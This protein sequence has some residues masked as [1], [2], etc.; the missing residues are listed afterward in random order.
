MN[1]PFGTPQPASGGTVTTVPPPLIAHLCK[2]LTDKLYEKRKAAALDVERR[3]RDL[4]HKEQVSASDATLVVVEILEYLTA[5]FIGSSSRHVRNGGLISLAAVAIALGPKVDTYLAAIVP[6]ILRCFF[7][8]DSRV[9]Y[10]ALESLYNVSKVARIAILRYF[11]QIF[12]AL[13]KLAADSDISVKNGSELLDRLLKDVVAEAVGVMALRQHQ[14]AKTAPKS[15]KQESSKVDSKGNAPLTDPLLSDVKP[16]SAQN[17]TQSNAEEE[18]DGAALFNLAG[19]IPLLTNRVQTLNPY[20]RLF[21]LKWISFLNSLPELDLLEYLPDLL[22]AL[23]VYLSDPSVDV[24]I[25][26]S[27]QLAEFLREIREELG[28]DLRENPNSPQIKLLQKMT[29]TLQS[30]VN[31][32]DEETQAVALKWLSEFLSIGG[33]A[34]LD[35]SPQI[36]HELLPFLGQQAIQVLCYEVNSKLLQLVVGEAE[37]RR[38]REGSYDLK[39]LVLVLTNMLVRPVQ[40][41]QLCTLEWLVMLCQHG[42]ASQVLELALNLLDRL[43]QL[44]VVAESQ[45]VLLKNVE[46]LAILAQQGERELSNIVHSLIDLF[47]SHLA[48]ADERGVVIVRKLCDCV[49]AKAMFAAFAN[50]LLAETNAE[51]ASKMVQKLSVIL[52]CAPEAKALRH[53]LKGKNAKDS[54]HFGLLLRSFARHPM[55]LLAL[56]LYGNEFQAAATLVYWFGIELEMTVE[57]LVDLDKLIQ[58]IESP[59]FTGLRL[60]LLRPVIDSNNEAN[61]ASCVFYLWQALYGILMLLPQSGAFQTLRNR[62]HSVST[63]L[64]V[65]ANT[66]MPA[67]GK[68]PFAG[69]GLT[70][71]ASLESADQGKHV[72]KILSLTKAKLKDSGGS[73]P[74]TDNSTPSEPTIGGL[75]WTLPEFLNYVRWINLHPNVGSIV[76]SAER[77]FGIKVPLL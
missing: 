25:N 2:S 40:E 60:Q 59:V 52:L 71:L 68:S 15:K 23:F 67:C 18:E 24:R 41:T 69:Y 29:R 7:D 35:Y 12:D 36:L 47:G 11:N 34:F 77:E 28:P 65:L 70:A 46:L 14:R 13:S 38:D 26:A 50:G 21:L 63:G 27:T 1:L 3:V 19:F 42:L 53:S 56:M 55:S 43:L 66:G 64:S 57:T 73:P 8:T 37:Q 33:S 51:F 31:S 20:T 44:L 9:R 16:Q 54:P 58:M 48:F 32:P 10:Y 76:S 4:V 6:P 5:E 62:L 75:C 22:H 45:A 72:A 30:H 74:L 61:D 17:G 49:G 39:A